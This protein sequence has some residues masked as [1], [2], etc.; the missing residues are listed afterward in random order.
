MYSTVCLDVS[1]FFTFVLMLVHSLDVRMY[2]LLSLHQHIS[3]CVHISILTSVIK[4]V[5]LVY[6][7][8][9]VSLLIT[10][11]Y[12]WVNLLWLP[13]WFPCI[14]LN[15]SKFTYF[16]LS[17]SAS[18]IQRMEPPGTARCLSSSRNQKDWWAWQ[19]DSN[20]P[21]LRGWLD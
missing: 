21:S 4:T 2:F 10:Q 1:T 9:A 3:S 8:I 19:T 14:D 5:P 20:H 16:G 11:P 17:S 7:G 6:D 13:I 18:L 12:F 15:S